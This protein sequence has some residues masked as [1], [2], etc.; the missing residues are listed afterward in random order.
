MT[1]VSLACKKVLELLGISRARFFDLLKAYRADPMTFSIAY[2]RGSTGRLSSEAETAIE[3]E[4]LRDKDLIDNPDLPITTYN[5]Q[6][7]FKTGLYSFQNWNS[8]QL[9]TGLASLAS[10][11]ITGGCHGTASQAVFRRSGRLFATRL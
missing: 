9:K 5:C 4:L 10:S 11:H 1:K 8:F 3:R 2:E 7:Q 6:M